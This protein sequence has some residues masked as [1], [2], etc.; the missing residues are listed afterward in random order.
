M[1]I[2]NL[3]GRERKLGQAYREERELTLAVRVVERNGL[4]RQ[5][6]SWRYLQRFNAWST[7]ER[8]NFVQTLLQVMSHN[9]HGQIEEFL[10]ADA[11]TRLHQQAAR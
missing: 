2:L 1:A 11:Q 5:K 8:V 10:P 9:E 7:H 4:E 3:D 6:E